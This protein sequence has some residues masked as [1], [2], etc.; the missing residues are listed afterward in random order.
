[1]INMFIFVF[2]FIHYVAYSDR[3]KKIEIIARASLNGNIPFKLAQI[4][5]ESLGLKLAKIQQ[6][7]LD[8][9][10]NEKNKISKVCLCHSLSI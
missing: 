8:F 4:L 5:L 3:I 1:M 7:E 10:F 9:A 6:T 2:N